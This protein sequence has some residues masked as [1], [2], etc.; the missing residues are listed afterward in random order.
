[1]NDLEKYRDLKKMLEYYNYANDVMS[2]DVETICPKDDREYSYDVQNYFEEK[3]L[4]ID[5]EAFFVVSDC[6]EVNG[7]FRRKQL[8]FI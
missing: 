3:V 6:Y 5:N 8:P 2:F 7:G 4:D 1:M